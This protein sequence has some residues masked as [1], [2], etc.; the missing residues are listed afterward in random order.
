[1]WWWRRP[2][3]ATVSLL[4][5]NLETLLT[6]SPTS[7]ETLRFASISHLLPSNMRLTPADAFWGRKG[8]SGQLRLLSIVY[9]QILLL[10]REGL[11]CGNHA[12]TSGT[13]SFNYSMPAFHSNC[14][15]TIFIEI[16]LGIKALAKKAQSVHSLVFDQ[17]MQ[18]LMSFMAGSMKR[19]NISSTAL[20]GK[21]LLVMWMMWP[22]RNRQ[23]FFFSFYTQYK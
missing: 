5:N 7:L 22:Q 19:D 11:Q 4:R 13:S 2:P 15:K 14:R 23:E 21:T 3:P 8:G 20:P 10:E 18:I 1:M 6:F 16:F 9:A 17:W 12:E